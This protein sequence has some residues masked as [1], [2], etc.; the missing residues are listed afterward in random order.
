MHIFHSCQTEK[1]IQPTGTNRTELLVAPIGPAPD[2][3][4]KPTAVE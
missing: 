4:S 3:V 2:E 1:N